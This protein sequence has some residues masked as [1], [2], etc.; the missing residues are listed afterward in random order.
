MKTRLLIPILTLTAWTAAGASAGFCAPAQYVLDPKASSV[1]FDAKST[2]HDF[3]GDAKSMSGELVWDEPAGRIG[4]GTVIRIPVM[5]LTT[6][7]IKRDH[8]MRRMFE[9]PQ[10]PQIEFVG[11]SVE[12]VGP[13]PAGGDGAARYRLNGVLR[14]RQAERPLVLEVTERALADGAIEVVGETTVSID[15]FGLKP[16]VAFGVMRVL[17]DVKIQF[18]SVWKTA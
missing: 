8:S 1:H 7:M 9:A 17:P 10:Y 5:E 14:I 11:S 6:G 15:W 18:K 3:S 12:R 2:F 4:D 16:P 13:V